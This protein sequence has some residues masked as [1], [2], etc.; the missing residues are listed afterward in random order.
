MD[1]P[2]GQAKNMM[3]TFDWARVLRHEFTHTVTLSMTNNRI[4]H[5]LTEAAACEQELSPRDWENCQMLAGNYRSGTLFTLDTLT[6]GFIKPKTSKDRPLA[7]ME[8][9]WVYQ[10]LVETY[11]Q[12]KML[13]FLRA[14]GDGQT[15]PQAFK[16]VYGKTQE[17]INKDFLVWAGKQIESWGLPSEPLPKREDLE[18]KLKD[19]PD[20]SKAMFDMAWVLVNEPGGLPKA[21]EQLEKAIKADPKNTRARELLGAILNN[22][23][24]REP[25]LRAKAKEILTKVV[26]EDESRVVAY[27]TLGLI[28]M[29][30]KDYDAAEKWF[31]KLEEKRPAEETSYTKLAG[32]YLVKKQPAKAI[33]QFAMLQQHE[34]H[35]DTIPRQLAILYRQDGQLAEAENSAYRAVRINP[36]SAVNH[37]LMAQILMAQRS[38]AT[39][40]EQRRALAARAAEYWKYASDLQPKIAEFWT[41]LAEASGQAGNLVAA[42]EAAKKAVE[43]QPNSPAKKWIRE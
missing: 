31:L 9:Q 17:E 13:E 19:N 36:Y 3:G 25:A 2:R 16:S 39:G 5:W 41:G 18:K 37:N 4:P 33:A 15:E 21:R 11:S 26:A 38:K 30:E 23:A 7:Y 32:I 12:P 34:Q 29:G 20:D 6:W 40:D 43:I 1:V 14:F 10:Y 27:R 8:S 35:D 28:A 42:S 22:M 24:D